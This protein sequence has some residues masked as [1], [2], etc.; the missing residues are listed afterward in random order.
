MKLEGKCI[1]VHKW[2]APSQNQ[3][4][5]WANCSY[6]GVHFSKHLRS[7]VN[8]S[9]TCTINHPV[10]KASHVRPILEGKQ[11]AGSMKWAIHLQPF[12]L[13]GPPTLLYSYGS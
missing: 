2:G 12:A 13:A 10:Y 11:T 8:S 6:V 5:C 9:H 3:S 7:V 4:F 1:F